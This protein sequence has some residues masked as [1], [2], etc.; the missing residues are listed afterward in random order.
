MLTDT[1]ISQ[2]VLLI[3]FIF[4]RCDGFNL[5]LR[6]PVIHRSHPGTM[7]GFSVALHRNRGYSWLL[8]GAPQDQ[9]DQPGVVRGGTVYR[10]S[11][12][13][14][15]S[16]EHIHFDTAGHGKIFYLSQPKQTDDKS[17]QW[18]GAT[19]HSSG[20]N[21]VIVAC[22][23]RYVYFSSN[24]KRREPIGTCW[25]AK[26]DF[27]DFKEYSPCRTS[28]W[29]YHR[30]GSCQ[31]G[32]SAVVS[33][34]GKNLFIGAV[35]SWYWQGQVFSQSV[36]EKQLYSTNEAPDYNDDS[37]L[38][39][40]ICSGKFSNGSGYDVAV[41]M[42][43]GNNLT[44]KVL[45]FNS[46]LY[47]LQNITGEQI[48]S[49][50]GYSVATADV[51]GDGYDDVAVG[52]PF[53][54]DLTSK[55]GDYENGRVYVYLGQRYA[56]EKYQV[57]DGEYSRGRFGLA[58]AS[59]GD[60]NMDSYQDLAVG[61][62]YGGPDGAGV[63]YVYH[64]SKEGIIKEPSQII[65]AQR[66]SFPLSTLGFSLSGGMDLD[67]NGYPDLLIGAYESDSVLYLRSRP[68][69]S[70]DASLKIDP[71]N[72]NLEEKRC[73]LKDRSLVSCMVVSFCLEFTGINVN[74]NLGFLYEMQLDA[75]KEVPRVYFLDNENYS[76]QNVSVRL[77]KNSLY[78]KSIYA[79]VESDIRDKLIPIT[80]RVKYGLLQQP[81]YR[82]EIAPILNL[83]IPSVLTKQTSIRKNCG[84][85]NVCIPDLQ[86]SVSANMDV[87][88]IGSRKRIDLDV[89]IVNTGEDA[90]ETT[91]YLLMPLDINYINIDKNK[92]ANYV[93]C[94]DAQTDLT[95]TND[96]LCDI[97]NPLPANNTVHFTVL[98]KPSRII[99]SLSDFVFLFIVNSTNEELEETI[100]DNREELKIPLQVK[101]E[102]TLNGISDPKVIQYNSSEITPV[103][104]ITESDAG[105]EVTH[106]YAFGNRGPSTIQE[107]EVNILWPTYTLYG[108]H[109]L[110]L[111]E[112]PRVKGNGKCQQ[113][114]DINPLSLQSESKKAKDVK[115]GNESSIKQELIQW[116]Q[117]RETADQQEDPYIKELICEPTLCTRFRCTIYE[118]AENE[119][120]IFV[121]R[122]RLWKDTID[123]LGFS[124]V[125]IS[126]K[127]VT[128]ITSLPYDVETSSYSYKVYSIFTRLNSEESDVS[129]RPVPL[130]IF[131]LA[132]TS[133][134]LLLGLL[135]LL[136]WKFGFFRRRRPRDEL[137]DEEPLRRYEKN[138]YVWAAED[139]ML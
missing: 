59:A 67:N 77:R 42:P 53:Y 133:G 8:V 38:G 48:G 109:L 28:A 98:L 23:P 128:R 47:I 5:D 101:V 137:L 118:L 70:V 72:I 86:I 91:M 33:K 20:E 62:P 80:V 17:N 3:L 12:I 31:A 13:Y 129:L 16:C 19:I 58:L 82:E 51:N 84:K 85:D 56:W 25:V 122:S 103:D 18:F 52:A 114:P 127:L 4:Y 44:G 119:H 49:Y 41:G 32:F 45:L 43:R 125:Q 2:R 111:M 64:G 57:V 35:G 92:N 40:S 115:S 108:K 95:E 15:N 139:V 94:T 100:M 132:V 74:P 110:Y 123:Q 9:T 87:Y 37:Y 113:V 65:G 22:A 10:C 120:V 83:A 54:S 6:S 135:A 138:G 73:S 99:T 90:F 26:S 93:S 81:P 68:I 24:L 27:S 106:I 105:P 61:A 39:Y 55:V 79:Y 76:Q 121:I 11:T 130:W 71:E 50:F 112:Q 66:F 134:L 124:D 104:K 30:Q 89:T 63:V 34:D 107:A 21:G 136:L 36:L 69:V 97:G 7:F 116:K 96:I 75:Y 131:I 60:L 14:S 29:G 88:M 78:C 46:T 126:S 117:K 102:V 1:D